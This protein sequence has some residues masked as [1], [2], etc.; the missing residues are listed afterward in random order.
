M[1]A[2][3]IETPLADNDIGTRVFASFNF[4]DE[5]LLLCVI[6]S[7]IIS[8]VCNID[9][10]FGAW[11]RRL[12]WAIEDK[13]LGILNLFDH[14]RMREILIDDDSINQLSVFDAS[15]SLTGDL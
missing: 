7:S 1:V 15:A 14:L 9:V 4:I 6:E 5:V 12:K 11:F 13:D 2:F 3:V 10:V 8:G